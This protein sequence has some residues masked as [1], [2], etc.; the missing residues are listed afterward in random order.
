MTTASTAA[1]ATTATGRVIQITG[2]V[3]D[4]VFPS[5]RLP[6]IYNAVEIQRP[7]QDPLTVEVQQHRGNNWVR[8]VAM[9]T[10]DGP[11]RGAD[12]M[13]TRPITVGRRGGLNRVFGVLGQPSTSRARWATTSL[14]MPRPTSEADTSASGLWT[15]RSST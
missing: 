9:T 14:P 13:H 5:G 10:T 3:V 7:G 8:T 11:A 15:D 2:A 1:T 6:A 12:G 4:I